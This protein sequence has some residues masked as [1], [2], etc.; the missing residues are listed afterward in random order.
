MLFLKSLFEM[1][2]R[3]PFFDIIEDGSLIKIC[4]VYLKCVTVL[5][6]MYLYM[7]QTGGL[8]F[9]WLELC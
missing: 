5:K 2:V 4:D 3:A 1:C 9:L 7:L 6:E 8:K